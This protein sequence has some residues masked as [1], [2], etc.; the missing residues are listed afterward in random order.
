MKDPQLTAT[1]ET[2][3]LVVGQQALD[4]LSLRVGVAHQLASF[5]LQSAAPGHILQAQGTVELNGEYA[6]KGT[7]D[8]RN[9]Q[10]GALLTA[11]LPGT[12]SGLRGQAELHGSLQGPLRQREKLEAE[13]EIPVFNLGYQSLQIGTV[14]PIRATYRDGIAT[15]EKCELKGTGTDLQLDGAVPL[16]HTQDLRAAATGTLDLQLIRLLYPAWETSRATPSGSQCGRRGTSSS[17]RAWHR[18]PG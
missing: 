3:K 14:S 18:T 2:P 10:L 4:G 8:V 9:I 13:V 12:P 1:I 16:A 7:V 5:Q 11:F 17:R 15:L 6:S